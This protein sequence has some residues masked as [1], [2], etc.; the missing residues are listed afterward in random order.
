[1]SKADIPHVVFIH[2][3]PLQD[4]SGVQPTRRRKDLHDPIQPDYS[5]MPTSS[6]WAPW[7]R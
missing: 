3:V 5:E 4:G 1:M 7:K 2:G 6:G